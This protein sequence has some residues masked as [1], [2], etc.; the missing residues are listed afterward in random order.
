MVYDRGISVANYTALCSARL[1]QYRIGLCTRET[2]PR[3]HIQ[4][5]QL[6]IWN[7]SSSSEKEPNLIVL[8]TYKT[9]ACSKWDAKKE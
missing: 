4:A 1:V 6:V 3:T 2:T 9:F 8:Y 7:L 5:A